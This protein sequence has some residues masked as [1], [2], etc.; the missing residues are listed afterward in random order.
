MLIVA[1]CSRPAPE[2]VEH[3]IASVAEVLSKSAGT[4]ASYVEQRDLSASHVTWRFRTSKNAAS[5]RES[6]LNALQPRFQ[7]AAERR[8]V[9][10]ARDLAGDTL[11]FNLVAHPASDGSLV[12]AEL[13]LMPN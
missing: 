9:R 10:C 5:F 3:E 2:G 1:G 7:C 12:L 4:R 6:V 11:L 8:R 13:T